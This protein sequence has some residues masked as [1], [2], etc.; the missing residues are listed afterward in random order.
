MS[1]P[2]VLAALCANAPR[3]RACQPRLSPVLQPTVV[4]IDP[5]APVGGVSLH[6]G[7][8]FIPRLSVAPQIEDF[9]GK[10]LGGGAGQMLRI[11]AFVQRYPEDGKPPNQPT[12]AFLGY[13]HKNLYVAFICK[14]HHPRRIRA[15]MLAR[16]ALSDDD[17]VQVMLDTFH[18]E[19]RAFV[20]ESNP[21]G[22]QADALYSEQNGYDFSFDTVWDTWG[23]RIPTGYVVLMRIPF[24]SL[25]FAKVA[26]GQMRTW[27]IILERA[28]PR[29]NEYD[30]WPRSNHNIAG[31]LTQDMAI[32]GFRDVAH[33]QNMQF[34]PY[35]LA[36]NLRQL[37]TVNPIDPYFQH[38]RL[39]GYGG[40]DA[41]FILH[42]SLVLDTTLNPDFS[43]V[44]I[45]N[46]A[47]PN[48][49]FPPYFPEVRPFFI[50][51]SSYFMTP[52]SL[53]YTDN[54]VL[55]QFGAR[56]TGKMGRWA[57]GLLGVDDRNPGQ[58]V[59]QGI[60]GY[61]KRAHFWVARLNRDLGSL[62]NVGFIYADR[63]FDDSFNRSGGFD[64]RLRLRNRWTLTGQGVTSQTLNLSNSTPG[65]QSCE[66]LALY[67]SG[68]AWMQQVSYSDLHWNWWVQYS[69]TASGYVTDTGFFLRP[70]VREPN[71]YLQHIFRPASGPILSHGPSIYMERIWDH[72]ELPLDYY[73]NPSYFINFRHDTSISFLLN[74]GQDRLR[75]IDY[76]ALGK[77][78]EWHSH[79]EQVN[80]SSAPRPYIS[81]GVGYSQGTVVNYSPPA[82][83]GPAPVNSISPSASLEVKPARGLDLQNNYVYTRFTNPATGEDVYNNH[84][85]ISRWNYQ[86]TQAASFSLIGEYISTLPH[87]DQTDLTNSKSLFGDAL[88]TYMPH[89]GT[90]FYVGYIGNFA[91]I[92]RSLC[93]R[94]SDGQCNPLEPILAPTGSRLMNDGKNLYVKFSYL[95]RF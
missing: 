32:E 13:T 1:F 15:H 59:P 79:T 52:I 55:P 25:Y 92:D 58:S 64:Y 49:R 4:A 91:N 5:A 51:N 35:L 36:R 22:I 21:L 68:Q 29:N 47:T 53:Y 50:E 14:D 2:V 67:C 20:F 12:T 24:A 66:N 38:K 27:G 9:L 62:S 34:E 71:G 65:E 7:H 72:T 95:L 76:P 88:F 87:P 11:H 18:D 60:P 26:P 6:P 10:K 63:E 45:D 30:F 75:P 83:Q 44:G 17:Y 70:D 81:I 93:T 94:E 74:L 90:A 73:F 61:G 39:Q 40:L 89:P 77:N 33:G 23:R 31:R 46:P 8:I 48:Q 57:V 3:A 80:F 19:R 16:D 43:Q 86:L 41:K 69:D 54:I 28:I 56:L 82:G 37:N 84:E 78:V 85:L 42:N